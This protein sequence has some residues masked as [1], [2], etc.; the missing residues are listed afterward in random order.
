[1]NRARGGLRKTVWIAALALLL[2]AC[3]SSGPQAEDEMPAE[4]APTDDGYGDPYEEP[5]ADPAGQ[6]PGMTPPTEH[7]PAPMTPPA[8]TNVPTSPEEVSAEQ[9]E[10]FADAY[11]TVMQIRTTYESKFA[12][13]TDPEEVAE[14][15]A[16]AAQEV[17]MAVEQTE[18]SIEEFNAIA[19]MLSVD[20][21]LRERVQREVD[22]RI[23]G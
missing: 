12:Q 17:Q 4:T 7:E 13:A 8:E 10:H 21:P 19:Q 18:L 3:S 20:E 22:A 15:E 5:P 1:M 23:K 11:L 2:G 16:Q 6:N 9:V 14:L